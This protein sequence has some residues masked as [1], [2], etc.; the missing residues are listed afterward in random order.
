M[1]PAVQALDARTAELQAAYD[2][3]QAS[4]EQ[5]RA[6]AKAWTLGL[7]TADGQA[8]E[9]P[10]GNV[11]RIVPANALGPSTSWASTCRA[12]G[13]SWRTTP[14]NPIPKGASSRPSS[15]P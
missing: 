6:E 4:L 2:Q 10:L 3:L 8:K 14:A 1:P 7:E 9:L 13:S 12:S 11:V 5:A 15:A